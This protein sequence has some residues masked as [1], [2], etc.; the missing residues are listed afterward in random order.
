SL[1]ALAGVAATFLGSLLGG[2]VVDHWSWEAALVLDA[3]S[4]LISVVSLALIRYHPSPPPARPAGTLRGYLRV[5]AEGGEV[6]QRK[7]TVGRA[8]TSLGAV[9]IGGGVLHVAGNPHIQRAASE[10]GM[11]R[12]GVLLACLA[13]GGVISTLW[14]NGPGK[15]FNAT[16]LLGEG[17]M[18]SGG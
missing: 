5:G 14:L 1:L 10:P 9:W 18:L 4:Y 15:R 6:G 2:V 13:A 17:L 12:L 8:M 11:E 16:R 7:R 3:I